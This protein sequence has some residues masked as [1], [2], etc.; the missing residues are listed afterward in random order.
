[1]KPAGYY[2]ARAWQYEAE[3]LS[4][5]IAACKWVRLACDRNR[6]DRA[7]A[8]AGEGLFVFDVEAA[9]RVCRAAEALPHVKGPKAKL[10]R[11]A[12]GDGWHWQT[13]E[14]EPWQC[15]FT[16]LVF[17]WLRREDRLRRFTRFLLLV[18]RKNGKALHVDTRVPTPGGYTRHGDLR[19][20]DVVFSPS[21]RP[22]EVLAV[23][24][25][26]LG[27]CLTV[28]TS[29][30]GEV[31]AHQNHEWRTNRTW[32]TGRRRSDRR[33]MPLVS[34]Q[35]IADTLRMSGRRAD[36][37][38]SL[39]VVDRLDL[40]E[41]QLFVPPY[42]LGA[43]LGDGTSR[44][45]QLTI[46]AADQEILTR[47]QTEG[48]SI[49]AQPTKRA[50]HILRVL[51]GGR[52]R[53]C[54]RRGHQRAAHSRRGHCRAC[55][56]LVRAARREGVAVP[57][58]SSLSLQE[59][60]RQVGVLGNKHIPLAY[61]RGSAQQRLSLLQGLM[62]TDGTI[63]RAGQCSFT[64]V[65]ESM[66][67]DV[68]CLV[69]SLGMKATVLRG[70]A[71]VAGRAV[72]P[73]WT[74][75]F[76]PPTGVMVFTLPRK[77]ARQRPTRTTRA[78]R[79]SIVS[80]EP[81]G[82]QEVNCIQVE[83]GEYVVTD[84]LIPT[85]NSV[86]LAVYCLYMLTADGESGADVY[87]AATKHDQARVVFDMA[88][89]MA[90]RTPAF[91]QYFGVVPYET[92]LKVPTTASQFSPLSADD[93][94]LDGLNPSFAAVDE[95]HAH[96]TRGVWDVLVTA[97]SSR[98]QPLLGAITT[99]GTN[100]GG[101]CYEVWTY[102]QKVLEG[103][104]ED[105]SFCAVNYTIDEADLPYWDTEP[106]LRKANPNWGISVNPRTT[107][108]D[109]AL[110]RRS[111]GAINNFLTKQA[112]IWV[113]AA[114]PWMP[115]NAWAACAVSDLTWESFLEADRVV[116]T[117]DLAEVRDIASIVAI[118]RWPDGTVRAKAR[119]FYPEDAIAESPIA[120][121]SGWVHEGWLV[122]VP[123]QTQDFG[124]I[125]R[126]LAGPGDDEPDLEVTGPGLFER[127]RAIRIG[128][129]RALALHLMQRL[130]KRLGE[131][132]ITEVKQNTA[133]FNP[134]M[135]ALIG[136]VQART[137]QHDGD[138]VLAWMISNVAEKKTH[139]EESFPVKASGKDS[140]EK[141]D[142]AVALL[143]GASELLHEPAQEDAPWNNPN[144]RLPEVGL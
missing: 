16:C 106:V 79:R 20:G 40:P 108:A 140:P 39:D 88:A 85:H 41:R 45:A 14:L 83:G 47:I 44:S 24:E 4:G 93:K 126:E 142:G 130:Q 33:P 100:L 21:G 17:G 13:I 46:H 97:Q 69:R 74:V 15:W 23:T 98:D 71:R 50:P 12:T 28:T 52:E 68:A 72:G 76:F 109:A 99:A 31:I 89:T 2:V 121:M 101:I 91:T 53:A 119:H 78:R 143:M 42:T 77:L 105:D 49:H 61:L 51:L 112:N 113:R 114:S 66:S 137:F 128:F 132:A 64:T 94:T 63:S 139:L 30:G 58:F 86:L 48:V 65:L 43:W 110:A 6:R 35:Q 62:D 138:P 9:E 117:V 90:R 103:T 127:L 107:L 25:P 116:I 67:R 5:A 34:T 38:H 57:P 122:A 115:M 3:V 60:L 124:L 118:G 7:R 102:A 11:D 134:A 70:T 111:P 131:D 27:S 104:V 144:Y 8:E 135:K 133:T 75:N 73:K 80:V 125:E 10:V 18:P 82:Q 136:W 92:Q 87:S 84:H 54:C 120:Q 22:I 32:Y 123:G 19:P 26:Y 59:R 95:L 37:V 81:A 129:D 1:M 29:D 96:R 141:I 56:R 55:E 36:L